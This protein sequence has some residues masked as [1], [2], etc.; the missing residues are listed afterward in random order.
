M[1]DLPDKP[2]VIA[3]PPLLLVTALGMAWLLDWL[4]PLDLMPEAAQPIVRLMGGAMIVVAGLVAGSAILAFRAAGTHIEPH[5]PTL[6]I[7][8]SGPYRFTRNPMYIGL[9]LVHLGV[10]AIFLN[11]WGLVTLV[12]LAVLLHYGVVLREEAYLT[13]KFAAEYESYLVST[14]RWA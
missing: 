5:K 7:V 6:V 10:S 9:M 1:T 11:E 12:P 3:F 2:G 13:R 8:D 4:I 14:R